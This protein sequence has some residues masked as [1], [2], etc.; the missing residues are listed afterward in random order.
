VNS[1]A[2][3]CAPQ[4][5]PTSGPKWTAGRR[6][7]LRVAL[8]YFTLDALPDLL[9]RCPG[10]ASVLVVYWRIWNAVLPW[11]G[12]FVLHA[13]NPDKLP[14]PTVPV[15]L[16]DFA[17]G[18]VLM[19]FFLLLGLAV[20]V[21]WTLAER[22]RT[23]Y[24]A[25]H[26]WLRVYVRYALACSMLGYGLGKLFPLQFGALR[27]VD[28]LTP[29]G[30]LEPRQLLWDF[31]GFSRSYQVFTGAVE[32]VGI[33]LLF[34]RRTT[35]LGSVLLIAATTNVLMID[36]GYGMGVR[37]I[38]LRLLLMALFLAA[39]DLRRLADVFLLHRP[40]TPEEQ[41]GPHWKSAWARRLALATK[42]VVIFYLVAGGLIDDTRDPRLA[43][44]PRPALYGVYKVQ[45]FLRNGGED[46][47][48]DPLAWQW[49]AI[50]EHEIAVQF[51]GASWERR[52]AVFDDTS[53]VITLSKGPR[54]KISLRYSRSGPDD[55]V[56]EGV[57]DNQPTEILLRRIPEP[58][59]PLNDPSALRWGS[60][61]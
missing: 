22:R 16:G 55:V 8:V 14:L 6:F 24:G 59:F 50:G 27:L 47:R 52:A 2:I 11:F 21:V 3:A 57:L 4:P 56:A 36:I 23:D 49:V 46:S 30:M 13:R 40:V 61:W 29:V 42:A 19:L 10:G 7:A 1:S 48:G 38:A 35:L 58:R 34:W 60:I 31:M 33:A 5:E 45:R 37:R 12:R 32:C 20:G 44:A 26:Y 43:V 41:D 18:Y 17:G 28:L 15:L 25:L 54:E 51:S 9:L 39:P 53:Q